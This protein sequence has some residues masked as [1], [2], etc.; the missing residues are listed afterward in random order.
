MNKAQRMESLI[1]E[2]AGQS[3]A[4]LLARSWPAPYLAYFTCFNRREF[5]T[6]HDVLEHLWLQEKGPSAD[7]YKA[8]IQLAGAFVHL[9]KHYLR[10]FHY[11][12]AT[13]LAPAARLF[14]LA[15]EN[16]RGVPDYF[17][18]LD[19][20]L[21]RQLCKEWS[22]SLE[23]SSC[24]QNPWRPETSPMLNPAPPLG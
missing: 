16:L 1:A 17:M 10:P 5:Y 23:A 8:L 6:A 2:I 18:G 11:K 21:L 24:T 14:G 12:D 9:Q 3:P 15:L 7:F 4:P 19:V 22:R 20:R 13:R